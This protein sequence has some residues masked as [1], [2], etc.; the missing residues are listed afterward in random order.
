VTFTLTIKNKS[1]SK[2]QAPRLHAIDVAV[3][4]GFTGVSVKNETRGL[5][6]YDRWTHTI[7]LVWLLGLGPDEESSV[8]VTVTTPSLDNGVEAGPVPWNAK[9]QQLLPTFRPMGA[10]PSTTVTAGPPDHL[11]FDTT[12][13]PDEQ[14]NKELAFGVEVLDRHD[15]LVTRYGTKNHPGTI[16][17]DS[18]YV[19]LEPRRSQAADGVA[20]FTSFKLT[21]AASSITLRAAAA[22]PY[23]NVSGVSK[24]FNVWEYLAPCPATGCSSPLV[25]DG[26]TS[27]KVDV[28]PS[29]PPAGILVQSEG[30]DSVAVTVGDSSYPKLDCTDETLLKAGAK[31]VTFNVTGRHSKTLTFTL[32][33]AVVQDAKSLTKIPGSAHYQI[34]Y[35]APADDVERFKVVGK[36]GTLESAAQQDIQVGAASVTMYVGVL[37]GCKDKGIEPNQPCVMS[38]TGAAGGGREFVIRTPPGDPRITS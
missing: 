27:A 16:G 31:G 13:D 14:L 4:N 30:P 7:R 21:A 11:A 18:A 20:R 2:F 22:Y 34:C 9:A 24:S 12:F 38:S 25:G 8:D 26:K 19:P 17:V 37:P 3:P 15:A 32:S 6:W 28:A 10:P 33:K 23:E 29:Q 1:S 35:A 36:N 5:A